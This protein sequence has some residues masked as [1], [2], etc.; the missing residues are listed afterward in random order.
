MIKMQHLTEDA[1][2]RNLR[3]RYERGIIYTN[4]GDILVS[5][6]PNRPMPDLYTPQV[7]NSYR[8][9]ESSAPHVY[10]VAA[11]AFAHM[12][13]EGQRQ[14]ILATGESG[15]GKTEATKLVINFFATVAQGQLPVGFCVASHFSHVVQAR[16][17][18]KR[19]C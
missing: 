12:Q 6:N 8:M 10:A 9:A 1:I 5:V 14:S 7:M 13:R 18:T 19:W 3:Q 17:F 11:A 16:R 2:V 15:A 4:I